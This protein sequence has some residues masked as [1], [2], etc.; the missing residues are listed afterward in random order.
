MEFPAPQLWA[1]APAAGNLSGN[2]PADIP[3]LDFLL[4]LGF[5][6]SPPS[7]VQHISLL[8]SLGAPDNGPRPVGHVVGFPVTGLSCAHCPGWPC[9]CLHSYVALQPM[10][11]S[12]VPCQSLVSM[13]WTAPWM[14]CVFTQPMHGAW[15]APPQWTLIILDPLPHPRENGLLKGER[16][17]ASTYIK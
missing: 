8:F 11:S 2:G 9:L 3:N 14:S 13:R 10:R 4:P 7:P 15:V 16:S 1:E 12:S 6:S 17:S 5:L